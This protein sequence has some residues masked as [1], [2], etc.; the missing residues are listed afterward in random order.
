MF[1]LLAMA[2]G[3][4][5]GW[6]NALIV[7]YINTQFLFGYQPQEM[8]EVKKIMFRSSLK[9]L[10]YIIITALSWSGYIISK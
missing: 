7:D 9:R 5:L 8:G 2:I 4:T 1:I 6:I 10:V 3:T